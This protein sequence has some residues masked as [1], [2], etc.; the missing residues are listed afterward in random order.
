MAPH[1]S[2]TLVSDMCKSRRTLCEQLEERGYNMTQYKN[3]GSSEIHTLLKMEQLD[4]I[5][6]NEKTKRK[7]YVKYFIEKTLKKNQIEEDIEHIFE[8]DKI[9]KKEN[10][11]EIIYITMDDPN[12]VLKKFLEQHYYHTK[13]F[14]TVYNYNRLL[15][16]VLEH[17]M[18]PKHKVLTEDEKKT[19]YDKYNILN[20]SQVAEI[21]RFDPVSIAIGLRP[22][23]L[24]EIERKSITAITSYYYRICV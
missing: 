14:I 4:M 16:N 2:S 3:F 23:E 12:D 8:E 1:T 9:L 7:C 21:S 19:V 22:G 18:V 24:C 10:N 11:D 15:Y 13:M 20:D 6:E 17:S 5:L